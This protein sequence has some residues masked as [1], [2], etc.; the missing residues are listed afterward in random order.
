MY[1]DRRI[2]DEL[3]CAQTPG[4]PLAW[5]MDHVRSP[6]GRTRHA[7]I[8]FRRDRRNRPRGSIQLYWGRTSPLEVR[9]RRD[10]RVRLH[11]D[12]AYREGNE[13]LFAEPVPIIRLGMIEEE[14]HVHLRRARDVLSD[15]RRQAFLRHEAVCHAGLMWRYGHDWQP[16]DPILVVDSEAQVGF[17]RR[18]VRD[19]VDSEI[20]RLLDLSRS[21]SIPRKLD[22][23]GVLSAGDL[24]LVEV[25][26]AT[27]NV[28]RAVIQ[29]AVHLARFARLMA[30]GCLRETV[31]EIIDQKVATG[32]IPR[33]CVRL[34]KRPRVVPCVAA[35]D[36]SPDW[37]ANWIK[38][39]DACSPSLV[40]R[41][42]GLRLIRLRDDGCIRDVR[43]R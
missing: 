11:A 5:L 13:K 28:E 8:Q 25:K 36:T 39:I 23:L 33:G 3:A 22:A 12:K 37:P 38:V 26:G 42:S 1:Y 4:E 14:L 10:G 34:R 35:P 24:A 27:G 6:E 2:D 40:A 16:T 21:T 17:A 19:T 20:R 31:Q 43:T 15:P 7:H 32:V 29:V 18:N 9:L 41:L 30:G